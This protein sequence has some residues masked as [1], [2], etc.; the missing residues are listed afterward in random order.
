MSSAVIEERDG[1]RELS[2][3]LTFALKQAGKVCC[4]EMLGTFVAR[5]IALL[6]GIVQ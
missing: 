6:T 5:S 2:L 3:H 1:G 4:H